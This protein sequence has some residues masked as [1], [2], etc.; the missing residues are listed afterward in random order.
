VVRQGV[1]VTAH[2]SAARPVVLSVRTRIGSEGLEKSWELLHCVAN[3]QNLICCNQRNE[4]LL[5]RGTAAPHPMFAVERL[6]GKHWAHTPTRLL[7]QRPEWGVWLH[8][9]QGRRA[10]VVEGSDTQE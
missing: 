1:P 6:A 9:S 4:Q 2:R 7:G 10:S 5:G 8:S 3:V